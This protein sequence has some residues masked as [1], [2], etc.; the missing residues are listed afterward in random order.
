MTFNSAL[1][2]R[3]IHEHGS[4]NINEYNYHPS[5][6]SGLKTMP[7][8]TRKSLNPRHVVF[9]LKNDETPIFVI[10]F[11]GNEGALS[12]VESIIGKTVLLA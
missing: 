4:S 12:L 5:W 8:E 2:T 9:F 3:R 6:D 10:A 1:A 11:G 7:I